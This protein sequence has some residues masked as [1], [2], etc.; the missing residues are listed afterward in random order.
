MF[1]SSVLWYYIFNND[2]GY[3]QVMGKVKRRH[4]RQTRKQSIIQI[5][6]F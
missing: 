1:L 6:T 4:S 5:G 3:K 2:S